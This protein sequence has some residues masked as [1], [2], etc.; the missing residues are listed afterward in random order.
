[1]DDNGGQ[2]EV[3]YTVLLLKKKYIQFFTH[4]LGNTKKQDSIWDSH[5]RFLVSQVIRFE[6]FGGRERFLDACSL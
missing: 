4:N 2:H 5:S 6:R 1:M 3:S